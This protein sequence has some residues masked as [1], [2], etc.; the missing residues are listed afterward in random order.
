MNP[1]DLVITKRASVGV[2]TGTY[3]LIVKSFMPHDWEKDGEKIHELQLIGTKGAN[4]RY[5]A[6]DLKVINASR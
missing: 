4:R 5:L 6:R 2:P 3:G 1:G